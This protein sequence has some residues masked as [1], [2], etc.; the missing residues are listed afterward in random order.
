LGSFPTP[1]AAQARQGQNEADGRR[2]QTLIGA[3][4]GQ[5]WGTPTAMDHQGL[6]FEKGNKLRLRGQVAQNWGTPSAR[7]YKGKGMDGQLVTDLIHGR[8]QQGAEKS[9]TN[10]KSL[11]LLN[12]AWVEQLM[13]WAP[14]MSSFTCSATEWCLWLRQ[15]WRLWLFGKS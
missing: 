5:A 12:P 4:R 13:A 14:G 11:G 15:Q 9:S 8:G 1:A 2:G 3:A 10:G 7:D 6:Y